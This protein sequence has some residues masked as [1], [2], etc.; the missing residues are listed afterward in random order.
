MVFFIDKPFKFALHPSFMG[1]PSLTDLVV[2]MCDETPWLNKALTSKGLTHKDIEAMF[3]AGLG[4]GEKSKDS[5]ILK[6]LTEASVE[7]VLRTVEDKFFDSPGDYADWDD[8]FYPKF[9][10]LYDLTCIN[11]IVYTKNW[12]IEN[13]YNSVKGDF[14]RIIP[15]AANLPD[16][17]QHFFN[18]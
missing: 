8:R 11:C 12:I 13:A 15:R 3:I 1:K 10:P 18:K 5:V 17:L 4:C 14:N 7:T 2:V 9:T 6:K 16:E